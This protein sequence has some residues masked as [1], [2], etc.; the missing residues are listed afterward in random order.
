MN[1]NTVIV[2]IIGVL[3]GLG[4]GYFS[5]TLNDSDT[6]HT[7]PDGTAM[8]DT[9]HSMTSSLDGKSG[10]EFDR[11]FIQ[12]MIVHHEGAVEMAKAALTSAKHAEIKQMANDIISAQSREIDTMRGWLKSWYEVE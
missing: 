11:A 8:S 7:M 9:M 6:M 3:I 4:G 1:T 2:G 12:E 5:A 10:D